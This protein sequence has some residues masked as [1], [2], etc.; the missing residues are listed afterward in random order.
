MAGP[1]VL[2]FPIS[3]RENEYFLL[4]VSSDGSRPLD[5]KLV[6]SE[7]TAVF[8]TKC[9]SFPIL[10]L[11]WS[12]YIEELKVYTVRQRKTAEY[13]HS[14]NSSSKEDWEETLASILVKQQLASDIE[15]RADVQSAKSKVTLSFQ[16]K[17]EGL[18]VRISIQGVHFFSPRSQ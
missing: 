6:G 18:A 15:I 14:S 7:S 9:E 17:I 13:K 3:G 5:L 2:R 12:L 11:I 16:K 4:E 10:C 8:V 1:P